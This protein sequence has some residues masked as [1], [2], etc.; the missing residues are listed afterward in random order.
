MVLVI[1]TVLSYLAAKDIASEGLVSPEG[2][3]QVL[4]GLR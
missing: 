3:N 4:D 1:V 2:I